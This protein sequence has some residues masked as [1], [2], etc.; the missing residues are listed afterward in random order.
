MFSLAASRHSR[1]HSNQQTTVPIT[2]T[3]LSTA[4]CLNKIREIEAGEV[5]AAGG[6]ARAAPGAAAHRAAAPGG[7]A[8]GAS[9][10]L[11]GLGGTGLWDGLGG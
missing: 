4:V 1:I 10:A 6:G 5:G 3:R 9:E 11:Q 8:R 7:A 2:A